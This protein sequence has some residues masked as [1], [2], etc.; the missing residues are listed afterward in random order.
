MINS[1]PFSFIF[2]SMPVTVINDEKRVDEDRKE[3]NKA[4]AAF[5]G[6][7]QAIKNVDIWAVALNGFVVYCIYCG[8]TYFIPF[9]N[10]IYL[11]PACSL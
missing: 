5:S 6:M 9:L 8:L 10:Q 3:V 7:I 1:V 2:V 4:Q 11:L